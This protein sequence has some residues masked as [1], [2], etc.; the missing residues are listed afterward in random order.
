MPACPAMF[1]SERVHPI[2]TSVPSPDILPVD[3]PTAIAWR[4]VRTL[5]K[6]L[7]NSLLSVTISWLF[8]FCCSIGDVFSGLTPCE[9]SFEEFLVAKMLWFHCFF[10]IATVSI[11]VSLLRTE[12]LTDK[13]KD[14]LP[15]IHWV[16]RLARL[17]SPY[18]V[19]VAL[20]VVGGC[21]GLSRIPGQNY[22]SKTSVYFTHICFYA[23]VGYTEVQARHLFRT[24][25]V[26][27]QARTLQQLM[28]REQ[29]KLSNPSINPAL[30]RKR[31][32]LRVIV[33]DLPLI[34]SALFA[35]A[36]VH[37]VSSI[38]ITTQ[39]YLTL[40]AMSSIIVKLGL[41][42]LAKSFLSKKTRT[43]N[44]R[45]MAIIVAAPTILVDTQLRTVLLCQD[46][47]SMTVVG[48][49]LLAAAEIVIRLG[50]TAY[51]RW[52]E[53]RILTRR[54]LSSAPIVAEA[55]WATKISKLDGPRHRTT[56]S[57][58]IVDPIQDRVHRLLSL[59]AAE[60]YSDMHAEY[61]AMGCSYG[62]LFFFGAHPKYQ[63]ADYENNVSG[64][65]TAVHWTNASITGLQLGIEII[66]DFVAC[67]LEIRRGIDFEQL[68]RDDSFLAVFVI[69]VSLVNVHI[70]SGMY[71]SS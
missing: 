60:I 13:F 3:S 23:F 32:F 5:R 33:Q 8:A 59:H 6:V 11:Y 43:P 66:V 61:I 7:R 34:A 1:A 64:R 70:S 55:T 16:R 29:R 35:T 40:F 15:L 41:Q 62:I 63:L 52:A 50:K 57:L 71:L 10:C 44:M 56:S 47:A 26:R 39:L 69:A 48:S 53:H 45:T 65:I 38:K 22:R 20:A 18:C 2:V 37:V 19:V 25:T 14:R 46:N 42:E 24:E 27:G 49:L 28:R 31:R 51:V 4:T 54:S 58:R 36:Y 68:N 67:A 30:A 9:Q 12:Q 17:T 21:I